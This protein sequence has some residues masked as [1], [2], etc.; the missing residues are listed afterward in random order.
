MDEDDTYQI[1]YH[2]IL[3]GKPCNHIEITE[4]R[5]EQAREEIPDKSTTPDKNEELVPG[6]APSI[7]LFV[8]GLVH[9][10]K[11]GSGHKS[12]RPNHRR[13]SH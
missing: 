11:H 13:G 12:A 6:D 9:R 1:G 8:G 2:N 5:H 4:S 7:G 10:R 3:G